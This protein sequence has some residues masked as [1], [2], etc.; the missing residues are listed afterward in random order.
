MTGG[1]SIKE[2]VS[3]TEFK[4]YNTNN[5]S[6]MSRVTVVLREVTV[7]VEM[8]SVNMVIELKQELALRL[9]K[10]SQDQQRWP[11]RCVCPTTACPS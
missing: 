1:H 2:N 7:K 5:N 4:Y 3:K 10:V 11:R 9:P 6:S 8:K